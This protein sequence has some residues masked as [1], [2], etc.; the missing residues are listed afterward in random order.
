MEQPYNA[1]QEGGEVEPGEEMSQ[2]LRVGGSE[3]ESVFNE[4]QPF[5]K[6]YNIKLVQLK[7]NGT[8]GMYVSADLFVRG[9]DLIKAGS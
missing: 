1:H 2:A 9:L 8:D 7:K 6:S 3:Q 4:A 5:S